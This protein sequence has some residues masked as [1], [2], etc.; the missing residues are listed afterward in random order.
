MEARGRKPG[1]MRKLGPMMK[2]DNVVWLAGGLPHKSAFPMSE[3]RLEM[4][5]DA[6]DVVLDDMSV[7]MGSTAHNGNLYLAQ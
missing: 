5:G 7:G 1:G 3:V 4:A 2:L 6:E